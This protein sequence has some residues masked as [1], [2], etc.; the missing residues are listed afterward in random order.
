MALWPAWGATVT[1]T[2]SLGPKRETF[3]SATE[4][5]DIASSAKLEEEVRV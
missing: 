4:F 1:S 5:P 2:N 3:A